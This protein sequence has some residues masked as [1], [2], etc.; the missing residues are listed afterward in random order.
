MHVVDFL[1]ELGCDINAQVAD[2]RNEVSE[3]YKKWGIQHFLMKF[4]S[5][6]LVR[7]FRSKVRDFNSSNSH[8]MTPL[9][10]FCQHIRKGNL[11]DTKATLPHDYSGEHILEYLLAN[12]LNPNC[13]DSSK[14]LPILYAALNSEYD[15]M[16]ILRRYKSEVN[17]CTVNNQTPL[18]E[19]VKRN[20]SFTLD[21]A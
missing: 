6:K 9:H 14:A 4:P 13:Y 3:K 20:K 18:I 15:F 8:L 5:L 11:M 7:Y 1:S 21:Q 12:G 10:L 16:V 2:R 19:I 17:F